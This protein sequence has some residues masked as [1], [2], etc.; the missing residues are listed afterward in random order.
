MVYYLASE[1]RRDLV[2]M[3]YISIS[4]GVAACIVC[5]WRGKR[6][7]HHLLQLVHVPFICLG[8]ITWDIRGGYSGRYLRCCQVR[9]GS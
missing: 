1:C 4:D 3:S 9:V 2:M 5:A 7:L 8:V 6:K